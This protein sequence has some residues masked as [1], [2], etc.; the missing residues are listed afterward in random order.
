MIHMIVARADD[1]TIGHE[2]SI[3]WNCPTDLENFK[4]IT[5]NK[6]VVMG[7]KT[8]ESLP[9]HKLPDRNKIILTRDLEYK[10]DREDV[11]IYHDARNVLHLS[12]VH[13]EPIYIIGGREIYELFLPFTEYIHMTTVSCSPGGDTKFDF[14][15]DDFAHI[16]SDEQTI[17]N[18]NDSHS[19]TFSHYAR[20]TIMHPEREQVIVQAMRQQ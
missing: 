10:V 8:Y 14:N 17:Q 4:E 19:M 2:G 7:R 18:E 3:P 1:D 5:E 20:I 16:T 9:D 11:S 12:T 6:I 15:L 13:P